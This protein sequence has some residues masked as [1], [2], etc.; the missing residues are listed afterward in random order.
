MWKRIPLHIIVCQCVTGQWHAETQSRWC[1]AW[2]N[3]YVTF[4]VSYLSVLSVGWRV[5][6]HSVVSRLYGVTAGHVAPDVTKWRT[7]VA[8]RYKVMACYSAVC[9]KLTKKTCLLKYCPKFFG[10]FIVISI[11]QLSTA[12]SLHMSIYPW[13]VNFVIAN[14]H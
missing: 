8:I 3:E 11:L 1:V 5:V 14:L 6:F 9:V 13:F 7:I 10:V 4:Q 2:V 12:Y